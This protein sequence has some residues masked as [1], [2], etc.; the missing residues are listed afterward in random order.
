MSTYVLFYLYRVHTEPSKALGFYLKIEK[1]LY[2]AII[3]IYLILLIIHWQF[4]EQ[5]NLFLCPYVMAS[6][7]HMHWHQLFL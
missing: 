4:L 7:T 3:P 2:N 5:K 1:P 6:L